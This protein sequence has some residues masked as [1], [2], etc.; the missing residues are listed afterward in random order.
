[1]KK[2]SGSEGYSNQDPKIY[3]Y[4]YMSFGAIEGFQQ[5]VGFN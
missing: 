1:M 2:A 3:L 4:I 5:T